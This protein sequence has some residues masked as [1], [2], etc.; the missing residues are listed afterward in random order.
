MARRSSGQTRAFSLLVAIIITVTLQ[1]TQGASEFID[2]CTQGPF[3]PLGEHSP[4]QGTVEVLTTA[5]T[6]AEFF[7]NYVSKS[8][9]VVIRGGARALPAFSLWTDHYLAENFAHEE[10]DFEEGKKETRTGGGGRM[11]LASF[12]E[13]Y[14]TTDRYCVTDLPVAMMQDVVL[15]SWTGCGG[16]PENLVKS[17]LWFSSG[18]TKSVLHSDAFGG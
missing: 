12:L 2:D 16:F 11:T 7:A 1:R 8:K 14:E 18:G 9:P 15:P 3:V 13:T 4:S 10:I 17:L 6:A 5:P